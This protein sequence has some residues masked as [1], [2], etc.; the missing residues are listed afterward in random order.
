MQISLLPQKDK[1]GDFSSRL[2]GILL[3]VFV[4]LVLGIGV[5]A[6]ILRFRAGG[7]LAQ[8]EA[9]MQKVAE[10]SGALEEASAQAALSGNLGQRASIAKTVLAEHIA[11]EQTLAFFESVAIPEVLLLQLSFDASGTLIVSGRGASFSA[12]VRQLRAWRGDSRVRGVSMS[13]ISTQTDSVGNIEGINFSAVVN[14]DPEVLRFK[15]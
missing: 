11:S 3:L 2:R 1:G 14:I 15:P 7:F 8:A 9:S 6:F 12:V 13:G 5:G 10:I 4:V